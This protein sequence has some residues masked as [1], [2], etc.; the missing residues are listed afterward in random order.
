[1][2]T[3]ISIYRKCAKIECGMCDSPME[4]E[5][6]CF[7]EGHRPMVEDYTDKKKDT[8]CFV[9]V[10]LERRNNGSRSADNQAIS[11]LKQILRNPIMCPNFI[12]FHYRPSDADFVI[13]MWMLI[14]WSNRQS[15]TDS[16]IQIWD[17]VYSNPGLKSKLA[18]TYLVSVQGLGGHSFADYGKS[19]V[20]ASKIDV[21]LTSVVLSHLSMKGF[22]SSLMTLMQLKSITD[23]PMFGHL[24]ATKV[25]EYEK[26]HL[27]DHDRIGL[28]VSK[29]LA[30]NIIIGANTRTDSESGI[31]YD[32]TSEMLELYWRV[33]FDI[34]QCLIELKLITP[35][36]FGGVYADCMMDFINK[37]VAATKTVDSERN[38]WMS[39]AIAYA[40]KLSRCELEI[41]EPINRLISYIDDLPIDGIP[42][43]SGCRIARVFFGELSM[44]KPDNE[45]YLDAVGLLGGFFMV[46]CNINEKTH[47][48][49]LTMFMSVMKN[50]E[51]GE[52]EFIDLADRARLNMANTGYYPHLV[53]VVRELLTPIKVHAPGK[54]PVALKFKARSRVSEA[55]D[56]LAPQPQRP[57]PQQPPIDSGRFSGL[58]LPEEIRSF[59]PPQQR[60]PPQ[61][62]RNPPPTPIQRQ[63]TRGVCGNCGMDNHP[64]RN[65]HMPPK[66]QQMC[67]KC[68]KSG[69]IAP[70]CRGFRP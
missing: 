17:Q 15:I 7:R 18:E 65:C 8:G 31:A 4:P 39:T 50:S 38:D 10:T 43:M 44:G 30:K 47:P 11:V 56:Q 53:D 57:A 16:M 23:D 29:F 55:D 5:T 62:T 61:Q 42:R 66:E 19:G 49:Q 48:S 41:K 12:G 34:L 1:M 67:H 28:E 63:G 36:Q 9:Y 3:P 52:D 14:P 70:V 13:R 33:F 35:T 21:N 24:F 68:G 58:R 46:F 40:I 32:P 20:V 22:M 27:E 6:S 26:V 59:R 51:L 45:K 69:H 2:C 37:A 64:T 60:A 54:A 25:A